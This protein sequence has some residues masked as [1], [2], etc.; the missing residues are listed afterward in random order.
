MLTSCGGRLYT[1]RHSPERGFDN[2]SV[3][4][5]DPRTLIEGISEQVVD[6]RLAAA[7]SLPLIE[8]ISEQVV[9]RRLAAARSLPGRS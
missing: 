4:C 3:F 8:G 5:A 9:D 7:R 1:H 6:R 2:P